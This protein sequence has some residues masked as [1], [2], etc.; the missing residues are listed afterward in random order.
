LCIVIID[1]ITSDEWP[2]FLI[3]SI[4]IQRFL[5][6]IRV[7]DI[8]VMSYLFSVNG[9]I[10]DFLHA[11][12]QDCIP[13]CLSAMPDPK[14]VGVAVGI[15]L[16][17]CLR[18]EIYVMSYPLLVSGRDLCITTYPNIEQHHYFLLRDAFHCFYCCT[19]KYLAYLTSSE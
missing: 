1:I 5:V 15:S 16:L 4:H 11:R 14:N 9:H 12:T 7:A 19:R 2:P 10:F 13:S 18:A 3:V 8:Y 6:Y 17:S